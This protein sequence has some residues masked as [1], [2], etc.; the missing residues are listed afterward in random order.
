MGVN[1]FTLQCTYYPKCKGENHHFSGPTVHALINASK[2]EVVLHFCMIRMLSCNQLVQL[3]LKFL[4]CEA[5]FNYCGAQHAL[6]CKPHHRCRPLHMTLLNFLWLQSAPLSSLSKPLSTL[7]ESAQSKLILVG[8]AFQSFQFFQWN[9]T[10]RK[11]SKP[12]VTLSWIWL[13]HLHFS[14]FFFCFSS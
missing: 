1:P 4:F 11:S 10:V 8:L 2:C 12:S 5:I 7:K 6:F 13:W 9:Q 3:R 14:R